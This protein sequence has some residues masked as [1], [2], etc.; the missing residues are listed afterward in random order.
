MHFLF[1]ASEESI[2]KTVE[3]VFGMNL[4]EIRELYKNQEAYL[5]K[6]LPLGDG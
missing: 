5:D 3:G 6:K 4:I 2:F 1:M